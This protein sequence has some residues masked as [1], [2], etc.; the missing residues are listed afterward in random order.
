MFEIK[1]LVDI[2]KKPGIYSAEGLAQDNMYVGK[3]L[4]YTNSN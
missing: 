2:I 4:Y 3:M 1:E